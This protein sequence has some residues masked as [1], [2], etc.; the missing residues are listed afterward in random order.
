MARKPNTHYIAK[1]RVTGEERVISPSV[2]A[3]IKNLTTTF[4]FI[5]VREGN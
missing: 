4:E 1:S 5:K 3:R 2:Y